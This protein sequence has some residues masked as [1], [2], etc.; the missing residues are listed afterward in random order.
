MTSEGPLIKRTPEAPFPPSE[1]HRLQKRA[2]WKQWVGA[3]GAVLVGLLWL[4][5]PTTQLLKLANGR[6]FDVISFTRHRSYT[7][8]PR[9]GTSNES[10]LKL[11]YY[12]RLRDRGGLKREVAE[13]AISVLPIAD[14]LELQL[15][16]IQAAKA[17]GPR[18]TTLR[19]SYTYRYDRDSTGKW[20]GPKPSR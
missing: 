16:W 3:V 13:V 20:H 11:I 17:I 1:L 4:L 8:N 7:L 9:N 18:F 5:Q 2:R 15:V 14:S 19:F 10:G 12:T 6:T